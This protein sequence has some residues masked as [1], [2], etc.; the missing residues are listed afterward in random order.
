GAA[1]IN[2]RGLGPS[3]ALTLVDG[4]R[5]IAGNASGTID[6]NIIP[7]IAIDNIEVITGGASSVY[8]ADALAGVTNIKLR[9]NFEGMEVRARGGVNEAGGDGKEWQVSTLIG[10]NLA[11]KGH[12]MLGIDYS[13][14]EISLWKNRSWFK[15]VMD[16]P[17]SGSGD[18]LFSPWPGYAAGTLPT[19]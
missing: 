11:G 5:A 1:T 9:S 12:A 6:L 14:R 16:S 10:V 7:Q 4:R 13:K 17:L 3:R 19:G 8:G 15:D 2:L 18:Y